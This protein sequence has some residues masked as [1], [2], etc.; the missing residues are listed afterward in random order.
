MLQVQD[1]PRMLDQKLYS[2]SVDTSIKQWSLTTAECEQTF[3]G[4]DG[5]VNAII[6]MHYDD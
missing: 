3:E 1:Q 2:A 5:G 6:L 4:H